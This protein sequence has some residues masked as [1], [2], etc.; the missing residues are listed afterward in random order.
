[1]NNKAWFLLLLI[2]LGSCS[3]MF[4]TIYADIRQKAIQ[5]LN[6]HQMI[7]AEQAKEG[8]EI[9][10]DHWINYL[11]S[12]VKNDHIISFDSKGKEQ[13]EFILNTNS[14]EISAVTRMD[15]RGSIV[16]TVPLTEKLRGADLSSQE[17]VQQILQNKKPVVSDVFLAMHGYD[18]IAIHVPVADGDSFEGTLGVLINFKVISKRFLENI[19]VGQTG[20]GWLISREGIELYCPVPGHTG[21]SVYENSRDFPS[22]IEL[23][24]N[25]VK[26]KKGTATY[27]F[28][29][30]KGKKR[31]I[32]KKHAVYMPIR[33]GN[34]FWSI[35]VTSSESE[36]LSEIE[37]FGNRLLLVVCTLFTG[38]ICFVYY[39]MKTRR[40]VRDSAIQLMA[41]QKLNQVRREWQDIFQA[42]GHASVILDT[43]HN[44]IA[45]NRAVT[46]AS[47]MAEE[48]L[49]G[50][51]CYEIF[52]GKN[53][54]DSAEGCPMKRAILSN[55]LET[56]EVEMDAFNGTFLVSCTPIFDEQGHISKVIHIATDITERKLA[57]ESLK[58]SEERLEFVL[59]GSQLGYW[60]W[61]IKT[62]KVERNRRWAEM[63][64]YTLK[65]IE[66]NVKQWTDLHHPDDRPAAWKSIM[67]HLKGDTEMHKLEYRMLT[68]D[69]HYKWILDCAKVVQRD[70]Q[71][72]PLRMSGTHTDITQRKLAEEQI[73]VLNTEL[74]QRVRIRTAQLEAA[75]KEL[76]SFSYSVSHDLRSP[77]RGIDGWSLA[78]AEEYVD[79]LDDQ[80]K[81]FI[82]RIRSETQ[83]MSQLIDAMLKLSRLT[84][85]EIHLIPI[86]LSQLAHTIV[87]R[88]CATYPK[89]LSNFLIQPDLTVNGD[90]GMIDIVL[91]NLI[92]NALKFTEKRALPRIEL[93]QLS[94]EEESA[95]H[96][97][98]TVKAEE[99][100]KQIFFIRD[101]GAGF[102]MT[103]SE[104]LFGAFQRLHKSNEFPGTGIGL[105]TVQRIVHRHGGQIWAEA[106]VNQG[107]TFYFTLQPCN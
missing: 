53:F 93:G 46:I 30:I 104:K 81:I 41:E 101:N 75:N 69:G 35:A 85:S 42:I 99:R 11:K 83:H 43:D 29:R 21:R 19:C 100:G 18:A 66:L 68:K 31:I 6:Q 97:E 34:T 72:A 76:E 63:L 77:L 74:E 89:R 88:L 1:M 26:G 58:E 91:T 38:A 86:N 48:E 16:Y 62:G 45:A 2:W 33:V 10:F 28:D 9:F 71:G 59:E 106:A 50:K 17:H 22:I 47:G 52:H 78:L 82:D 80:G 49:I 24:D 103:Y 5:E 3:Y 61:N 70:T 96:K 60:D 64:G 20:Y 40:I 94:P 79:I 98:S 84:R 4:H 14:D 44:I 36:L 7:G 67:D 55:H 54:T 105:A 39:A 65:E 95:S 92:G 25:M 13:I 27:S 51:K 73:R 23:A 57:V 107:A 56:V 102:D 90:L 15:M 32:D 8:I 87:S 37:E 12:L